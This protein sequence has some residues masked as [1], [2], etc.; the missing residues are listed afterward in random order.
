[1]GR[2]VR[3]PLATA[4]AVVLAALAALVLAPA[5]ARGEVSPG[6]EH[7]ATL[8]EPALVSARVKDGVLYASTLRGITAYD[9]RTDPAAPARLGELALPNVQNEDVDVGSGILLVSDEPY[10]GRGILHV[11]DVRDP[12]AMRVVSTYT[13]WRSGLFDE[14]FP[15]FRVGRRGG[16]GHTASCVQECRWAWLAGAGGGIEVVDL[17]DPA[18]PR[19]AGRFRTPDVED[20]I[21]THDVQVDAQGLAWVVG[22]GGAVGY[23]TTNPARPRVVH[24]TE[25]RAGRAPLNDLILHDSQRRG[26]VLTAT[27]ETVDT[28]CPGTSSLQTYRVGAGRTVRHLDSW[29]VEA[30]PTGG[31]YCSAH[32]HDVRDGLVA[33]GWYEAGIRFLDVRN[34]AD[35]RQVGWHVP[36]GS[37]HWQALFA[38]DDPAGE[39]VYALDHV[40]GIDVLRARRAELAPRRRTPP[41]SGPARAGA[42]LVVFDGFDRVRPGQRLDVRLIAFNDSARAR[43][44][45]VQVT[46][47]LPA[48][49]TVER[50][51]GLRYDRARREVAFTVRSLRPRK[52][53]SRRLVL[54]VRRDAAPGPLELI[55][56]ATVAG[57]AFPV[58]DR[59][60][61]RAQIVTRRGRAARS[62]TTARGATVRGAARSF[63]LFCRLGQGRRARPS[64]S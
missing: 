15:R 47:A 38:P 4:V 25:R 6:V 53:A 36:P 40:R 44:R 45:A 24:Q 37:M 16:L 55:G 18:R 52:T 59:G 13:T 8:P 57:E 61:D 28:R 26:N 42:G 11:V 7:L 64:A 50:R 41:R 5:A 23:D 29:R 33:Q 12:R 17:R 49:V 62:G 1:V 21:G 2:R 27:E 10:G 48:A 39:V 30:H 60:V 43:A 51:R 3:A 56:A 46:L 31:V 32:Y 9:V 19:F 20:G 58:T 63:R 34:P 54:R 14:A 35:I 22:S